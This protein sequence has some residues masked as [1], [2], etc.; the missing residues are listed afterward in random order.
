VR[1]GQ[2]ACAARRVAGMTA[3][4]DSSILGGTAGYGRTLAQIVGGD[5]LRQ[6]RRCN[7]TMAGI[8]VF[9]DRRWRPAYPIPLSR[10]E[11]LGKRSDGVDDHAVHRSK[12]NG[13]SGSHVTRRWREMDSNFQFLVARRSNRHA[14]R[15]S[16]KRERIC[17]GTE[18]SNPS[19]SSRESGTNCVLRAATGYR[20]F[21]ARSAAECTGQPPGAV[22]WRRY[23]RRRG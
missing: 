18:G 23:R 11:A 4:G 6:S 9:S 17:W 7:R 19:P 13:G 10:V 21:E 22:R 3:F 1:N 8:A 16:R 5:T 12:T 15:D 2:P 20:A 14:T